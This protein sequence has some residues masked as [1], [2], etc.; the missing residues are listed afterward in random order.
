MV[1]K[2]NHFLAT[3]LVESTRRESLN[4]PFDSPERT[5]L[6]IRNHSVKAN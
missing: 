3:K 1:I 4:A 5:P 6:K 2:N